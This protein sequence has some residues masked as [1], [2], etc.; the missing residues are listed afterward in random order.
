MRA[1][2]CQFFVLRPRLDFFSPL[3]RALELQLNP[4][5]PVE[6][7]DR[8][9]LSGVKKGALLGEEMVSFLSVP[10]ELPDTGRYA[11]SSERPKNRSKSISLNCSSP[12]PVRADTGSEITL[13]RSRAFCIFS[14][15][16]QW[17]P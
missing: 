6:D 9:E 15:S 12:I 16:L 14:T 3:L 5:P 11:G 13:S 17:L 4:S 2:V 1:G 10:W 7:Q 8:A